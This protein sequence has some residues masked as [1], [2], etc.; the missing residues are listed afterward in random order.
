MYGDKMAKFYVEYNYDQYVVTKNHYYLFFYITTIPCYLALFF[1]LKDWIFPLFSLYVMFPMTIVTFLIIIGVIKL[2]LL[3]RDSMY[4]VFNQNFKTNKDMSEFDFHSDILLSK[5]MRLDKI[6]Y[7]LDNL[8]FCNHFS[9]TEKLKKVCYD[10][11]AMK[12]YFKKNNNAKTIKEIKLLE[13]KYRSYEI[14]DTEAYPYDL[15]ILKEYYRNLYMKITRF[16]IFSIP[17]ILR[18]IFEGKRNRELHK[19]I[20]G[21]ILQEKQTKE[22]Y[23]FR[24]E[25][26]K[27]KKEVFDSI[28]EEIEIKDEEELR[29]FKVE[30]EKQLR[31]NELF[32]LIEKFEI[33]DE[34]KLHL[35]REKIQK[36]QEKQQLQMEQARERFMQIMTGNFEIKDEEEQKQKEDEL[37]IYDRYIEEYLEQ[38]FEEITPKK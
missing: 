20:H 8:F 11:N 25:L 17:S 10:I 3:I 1:I 18:Y 28:I 14:S 21:E 29:L 16:P 5:K 37:E 34:E 38:L 36:Q 13:E 15:D 33:K 23:L 6:N 32:R 7:E 22:V 27:K 2:D 26:K 4:L 24:E 19:Q 9:R 35:F 31:K 30:L 12:Y